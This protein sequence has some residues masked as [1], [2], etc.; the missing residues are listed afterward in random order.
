MQPM[1]SAWSRLPSKQGVILFAEAFMYR[2]H[3]SWQKVVELI[4]G[5][6]IGRL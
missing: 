4:A 3:P 1:Q 2:V 5:G 6:R